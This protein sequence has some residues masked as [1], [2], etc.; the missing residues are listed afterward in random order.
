MYIAMRSLLFLF[1]ILNPFYAFSKG[2]V[3]GNLK[4]QLGNQMFQIAATIAHA[5]NNDADYYFPDLIKIQEYNVP[6]NFKKIFFRIGLK[7]LN[8]PFIPDYTYNQ[9]GYEYIPI[10]YQPCMKLDGYFQSEK[11][12]DGHQEEILHLFAPSNRILSYL[13][14]KYSDIIEDPCSVAIHIR[15][16]NKEDPHHLIYILHGRD[17]V[18]KAVEYFPEDSLFVVFSDDILWCQQNL[19]G[20]RPNMRFIEGENYHHDFYL[21]SLCK[22]QIIS[23]SSFSWWAAYLNS[24]PDKIVIAPKKW[25]QKS[26]KTNDEDIVPDSWI[27]LDD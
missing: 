9:V 25:F 11:F 23:N 5:R 14:D 18:E 1:L 24:N 26:Y 15:T 8:P 7:A 22:H 27:S 10:P 3:V 17:Y 20:I 2:V 6:L 12:F 13:V 4:G 16:Y 21:I 19:Q